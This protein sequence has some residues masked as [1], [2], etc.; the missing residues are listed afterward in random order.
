MRII[1]LVLFLS[2]S[3][4]LSLILKADSFEYNSFNNHGVIG[5]VNMP[6]ARF[7]EES[8]YGVTAYDGNPDQ[9]L[10]LSSFP[11]DWLEASF[12]YTSIKEKPYC[13]YDYDPVCDQ[14]YKDKGFNFK[15]IC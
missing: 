1:Y 7:L 13:I 6:T 2:F 5:L 3:L 10:T 4:N 9:K 14:S 15:V 12:F 11:F 8:S